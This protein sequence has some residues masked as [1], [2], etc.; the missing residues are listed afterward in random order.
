MS[1]EPRGGRA[2]ERRTVL[3]VLG[4]TAVL[5]V[6]AAAGSHDGPSIGDDSTTYGVTVREASDGEALEST[7]VVAS[8]DALAEVDRDAGDQVRVR[9]GDDAVALYTVV[10]A[11]DDVDTDVIE[12]SEAGR[13]RLDAEDEGFEAT[14]DATVPHPEL[15]ASEAREAGELIE[16]LDDPGS[17]A[18]L[19]S[20]P[21][22]GRI[23]PYTDGQGSLLADELD[24][25]AT[26]WRCRGWN[27]SGD[28]FERWHVPTHELSP[29]SFPRLGEI[30][31]REFEQGVSFQ[32]IAADGVRVGGGAPDEE[33]AA[34]VE[35]I[36]GVVAD[37][38]QVEVA[39]GTYRSRSEDVLINDAVADDGGLWIGQS[40]RAR[41]AHWDEI[42][43]AV[44]DAVADL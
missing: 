22:G 10:E 30:A 16:R 18:L 35:A 11:S 15:S 21:H 31:D 43:V 12:M 3:S 40:F 24:A 7:H 25:A 42:V 28:A 36:E 32:G 1:D 14:V 9:R 38:V 44:A 41:E 23:E 27:P 17:A 6:P 29:A 19:I 20:A 26:F 37:D 2:V 13:E 4:A 33:K 39:T 5:G 34:L 8:A